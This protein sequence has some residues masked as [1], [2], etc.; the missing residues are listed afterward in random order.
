MSMPLVA[1]TQVIMDFI[2][3]QGWDDRQELG[4]PLFPGPFIERSP[5]KAVFITGAG[6]PGYVLDGAADA[7]NFQARVRGG[8]NDQF[9]AELAAEKLDFLIYSALYP[10]LVDGVKIVLISRFGSGPS[11]LGSG[12]DDALRWEYTCDYT[13]TTGV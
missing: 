4:F 3:G 2:A 8:Q 7:S 6:G 10:A 11:P 9:S 13:M 1:Q 12:P 5:D